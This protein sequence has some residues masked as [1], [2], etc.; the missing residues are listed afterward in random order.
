MFDL[1]LFLI[2]VLIKFLWIH[3]GMLPGKLLPPSLRLLH[4]SPPL[5]PAFKLPHPL[6]SWGQILYRSYEAFVHPEPKLRWLGP[7]RPEIPQQVSK[8]SLSHL[9]RPLAN[10]W[11]RPGNMTYGGAS[12]GDPVLSITSPGRMVEWPSST[13]SPSSHSAQTS[14][15]RKAR[16]HSG[17]GRGLSNTASWVMFLLRLP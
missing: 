16:W 8:P 6:P 13:V 5:A 4:P 17:G 10:G 9:P 2:W 12:P 11:R 14:R 3:L 1:D 15:S 7:G